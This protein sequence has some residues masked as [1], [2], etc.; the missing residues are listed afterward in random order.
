VKLEDASSRPPF[1]SLSAKVERQVLLIDDDRTMAHGLAEYLV[2][3]GY[4]LHLAHTA[5]A[6]LDRMSKGGLVL[7]VLD[8]VLP[9]R[10]GLS[11]LRE[12]RGKSYIPIIVLTARAAVAD[13]VAGLEAGADD[14]IPKPC[15]AVELLARIR[16]VLRRGQPPCSSSL[17]LFVDD[18][19][20]DA[21]SR[22]V[23]RDGEPIEC[24]TAE[25][26]ALHTLVSC[27]GKVVTREHLTQAALGRSVSPGDRGA[28]NLISALR[29]KLGSNLNGR[30]RFRSVRSSGYVYVRTI[31][32]DVREAKP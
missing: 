4:A 9:D 29:R 22:T 13:K 27:L 23:A 18:L 20:L 6:G 2:P 16:T 28:D 11:V 17:F 7:V 12:I 32:P 26:N 14:Y 21:G 10:D 5:K 1:S 30:D 15:T 19:I 8:V 25:F 3:E 24:T 31:P